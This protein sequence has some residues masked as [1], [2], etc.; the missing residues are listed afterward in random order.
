[1][2]VFGLATM[3]GDRDPRRF[4]QWWVTPWRAEMMRGGH[5]AVT[6]RGGP[7]D[8]LRGD[9]GPDPEGSHHGVSLGQWP[10]TSVYRL[11]HEG[12]YRLPVDQPVDRAIR[13]SW[14]GRGDVF[15]GTWGIRLVAL[16]DEAGGAEWQTAAAPRGDIVTAVWARAGRGTPAEL[17]APA[18]SVRFELGGAGP[19]RGPGGELRYVPTGEY[20]GWYLF[21]TSIDRAGPLTLR[22]RPRQQ[23]LSAPKY[24][25]PEMRPAPPVPEEWAGLPRVPAASVAWAREAPAWRPIAIY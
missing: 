8:F 5:L 23:M 20:E 11:M 15:E 19:W 9:V 17:L 25:L 6:V 13:R 4:A 10:L 18:G 22:V 24:F 12:E 16:D 3:R 1:M 14:T 21:R 7:R 2:P